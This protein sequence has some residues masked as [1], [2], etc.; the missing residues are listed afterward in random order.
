MSAASMGHVTTPVGQELAALSA[1]SA[2]MADSPQA[3]DVLLLAS[4]AVLGWSSCDV[5]AGYLLRNGELERSTVGW[6][7]ISPAVDGRVAEL[8]GTDGPVRLAGRPWAT[9][10]ALHGSGGMYG[11]LVLSARTVPTADEMFL[12]RLLAQ[13]AGI[14]VAGVA[15][16]NALHE[17]TRRL[18]TMSGRLDAADE[19]LVAMV[20]EQEHQATVQ[21]AFTR[22]HSEQDVADALHAL[23]GLTVA[24]ED[25]FGNVRCWAG[26]DLPESGARPDPL[27]HAE[28]LR[29]AVRRGGPVRDGDRMLAVSRP[30]QEI[31]G[32]VALVGDRHS[33]GAAELY[34]LEQAAA[35]LGN[36][37][38][39]RRELAELE[40]RLRGDL[41]NDLVT[42]GVQVRAYARAEAL[43]HDLHG[44]HQV[45][46]VRWTG[47]GVWDAVLR[48]TASLGIHCLLG[49]RSD[50]VVLVAA[51]PAP[52]ND[53]YDLL[54]RDLGSSGA[55]GVGGLVESPDEL[56]RSFDEA[57]Q[58][59]DISRSTGGVV[60]FDDLG[61]YRLLHATHD[62]TEIKQYVRDWLGRLL[63]YD[64]RHHAD[65]TN[66]LFHYL[67]CG[68][69]YTA[70]A[71]ALVIHRS[72][73][74]YRLRRIGDVGE[75]DL[76]DVDSRLNLHVAARAWHMLTARD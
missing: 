50:I 60:I 4:S 71:E 20:A 41:V 26:P 25:P 73:L 51:S 15:L 46:A 30:R 35:V 34:A 59:L 8:D 3:D 11:Y 54:D 55:V 19:R 53:L 24:V 61:L 1:L 72:T 48:A 22:E 69:N 36:E 44:A 6:L 21:R 38:A 43:G 23:T 5:A 18:G 17:Q 49:T 74:R 67:E 58:A 63:D 32:A 37:L 52:T 7:P 56:P 12:L 31:L 70:T 10:V 68:G 65:L 66:T 45:L 39:H 75:I 13:Q 62:G 57:S 47:G 40:S 76:H 27:R 16:R 29:H 9:A 14:A 28:T 64:S 2:A 42:D 33:V